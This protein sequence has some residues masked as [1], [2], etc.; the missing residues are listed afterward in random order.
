M[1]GEFSVRCVATGLALTLDLAKD[2]SAQGVIRH[3]A[4]QQQRG[5]SSSSASSGP[6]S[7]VGT[8]TGQYTSRLEVI[9]PDLVGWLA[10]WLAG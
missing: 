9:C 8:I 6:T 5:S 1:A 10:G 3:K 2:G 4:P 7:K